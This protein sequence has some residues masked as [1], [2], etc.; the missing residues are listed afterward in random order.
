MLPFVVSKVAVNF[1]A[2]SIFMA[3]GAEYCVG[4]VSV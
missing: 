4:I 3:G 2:G 1:A